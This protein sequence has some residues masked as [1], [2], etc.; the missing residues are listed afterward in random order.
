M[1]LAE[2]N[3]CWN[4]VSLCESVYTEKIGFN[5][6]GSVKTVYSGS[7]SAR[8]YPHL[9]SAQILMALFEPCIQKPVVGQ[10]F[11]K[12]YRPI[13]N[14]VCSCSYHTMK[15][16]FVFLTVLPRTV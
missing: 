15:L 3:A 5:R 4:S 8:P 1:Q 11:C 13:I 6:S 9:H 12:D 14:Y 7:R 2:M 10:R 16:G